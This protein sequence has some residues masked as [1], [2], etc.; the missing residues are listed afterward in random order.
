VYSDYIEILD[1]T[2]KIT[3]RMLPLGGGK[4]TGIKLDPATWQAIDWLAG[5]KGQTWQEWCGAI[6]HATSGD[7]NITAAIRAAAMDGILME[8]ILGNRAT[9]IDSIAD[10]HPLLR[11]SAMMNDKEL[12]EHMHKR[13]CQIYGSEELGGFTVHAGKDEFG[14]YCL[15]IENQ[16]KGGLSLV[17]PMPDKEE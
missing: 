12:A 9:T 17:I 13:E 1:I 10:E 14:R 7:E 3:Q 6:V 4:R 5:Q 15:W 16:L 2:M 8:T 11:Y